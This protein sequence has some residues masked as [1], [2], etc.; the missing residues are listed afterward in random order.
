MTT[1][2][3]I[4]YSISTINSIMIIGNDISIFNV[5]GTS[6]CNTIN[7]DTPSIINIIIHICITISVIVYA[8]TVNSY[9]YR[10]E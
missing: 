2:M 6:V 3:I 8:N 4:N 9:E 10:C 1:S 7:I 5:I